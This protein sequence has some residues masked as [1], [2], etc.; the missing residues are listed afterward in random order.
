MAD[1]ASRDAAWQAVHDRMLDV[2]K[3]A[4]EHFGD[5][6]PTEKELHDFLRERLLAEGRS[7]AEADEILR[8][9]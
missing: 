1:P 4:D 6:E 2:M 9:L 7:E 3:A 5:H 8:E